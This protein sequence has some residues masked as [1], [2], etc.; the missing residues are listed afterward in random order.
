MIGGPEREADADAEGPVFA[1]PVSAAGAALAEA[2]EQHP[3]QVVVSRSES[4][5]RSGAQTGT[6]SCCSL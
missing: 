2:E 5:S 1:G 6:A 4:V 3:R